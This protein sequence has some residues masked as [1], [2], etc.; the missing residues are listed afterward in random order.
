MSSK[1]TDVS[2][3]AG[4][5][6]KEKWLKQADRWQLESVL[7]GLGH[8]SVKIQEQARKSNEQ[9]IQFKN[10]VDPKLKY[11]QGM[12]TLNEG[13]SLA[14]TIEIAKALEEVRSSVQA[15]TGSLES[16]HAIACNVLDEAIHDLA[17]SKIEGINDVTYDDICGWFGE[18]STK[19]ADESDASPRP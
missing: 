12:A 15:L 5:H 11:V 3:N 6:L 16:L 9:C 7:D 10:A 19:A 2:K 17:I 14:Q 18:Y 1:G 13:L 4:Q 8:A